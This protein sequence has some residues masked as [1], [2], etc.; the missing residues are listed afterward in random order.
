[1][2]TDKCS[3]SIHFQLVSAHCIIQLFLSYAFFPFVKQKTFMSLQR[4][5]LDKEEK[6]KL[7]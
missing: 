3:F 2:V 6:T 4:S 1:M 5:V 7:N